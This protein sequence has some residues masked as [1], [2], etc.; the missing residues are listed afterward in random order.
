MYFKNLVEVLHD[1]PAYLTEEVAE[2][3][4]KSKEQPSSDFRRFLGVKNQVLG[5]RKM[6]VDLRISTM[7]I[8][9]FI[10]SQQNL[11]L[12]NLVQYETVIAIP[13]TE[14]VSE[15]SKRYVDKIGELIVVVLQGSLTI[16]SP[17]FDETTTL[18]SGFVYRINNRVPSSIT[19]ADGT[20]ALC[21]L[22]IDFDLKHY[23][24]E[25]D[26][27]GNFLR[28]KEEHKVISDV[29]EEKVTY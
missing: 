2:S 27:Q 24:K 3:L 28:Q 1:I 17:E 7:S 5:W 11:C 29:I 15:L 20:I 22:M 6:E 25:W 26:L 13:T 4:A 10:M 14:E 21:L 9:Q 23:L 16:Q 8:Q 19:V 12:K 18:T